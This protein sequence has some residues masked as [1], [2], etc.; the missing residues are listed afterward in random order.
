MPRVPPEAHARRSFAP[1]P[2][3]AGR[4]APRMY[5]PGKARRETAMPDREDPSQITYERQH[6][7][8]ASET[9]ATE[10]HPTPPSAPSA[11]ASLSDPA[12]APPSRT[13]GPPRP[14][15]SAL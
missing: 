10:P 1:L 13:P 7:A 5:R 9:D 3:A 2:P 8:S 4:I 12:I 14:S 15:S 11:P 6:G